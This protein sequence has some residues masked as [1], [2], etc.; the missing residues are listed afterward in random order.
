MLRTIK[1]RIV[2]LGNRMPFAPEKQK[3][4]E[5][6]ND[7]YNVIRGDKYYFINNKK[8]SNE[9]IERYIEEQG[10]TDVDILVAVILDALFNISE[11]V[12]YQ[13]IIHLHSF[14]HIF[15]FR[16]CGHTIRSA[17]NHDRR[18]NNRQTVISYNLT[19]H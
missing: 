18:R 9:K 12:E 3:Y 8:Q 15:T 19:G 4:F 1:K 14:D 6:S 5:F 16:I 7:K 13:D 17:C 2:M 10:Y 11:T